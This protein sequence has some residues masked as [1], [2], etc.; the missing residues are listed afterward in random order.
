MRRMADGLVTYTTTQAS[1]LRVRHTNKRIVAAPNALYREAEFA[2]D[3]E[4]MRD[5][6]LYVGRLHKDK[7]PDLLVR[8]FGRSQAE[9]SELRLVIV[10]DGDLS[11]DVKLLVES[12][13]AR[14]SIQLLGFVSDYQ[15]LRSL[16]S[17][18]IA[19]VSPGYVGL[20]ITQ[21]LSFGVP[22]I[23]SRDEDHSP[24]LEAA[25]EWVN[26]VFFQTD[27]VDDLSAKILDVAA[28]RQTWR[29]RGESIRSSCAAKYSVEQMAAGLIAALEDTLS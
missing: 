14:T 19:T 27:S 24:E 21:S 6:I 23:I 20:S 17:R 4:T 18:A 12:S 15:A 29:E 7:K 13:P 1:E 25:E 11:N 3:G 16:Y 26:C 2:F 22:M 5:T 9:C 10:G 8:A 28:N